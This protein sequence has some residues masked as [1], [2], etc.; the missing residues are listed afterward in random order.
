[1]EAVAH[2]LPVIATS[3]GAIPDSI[4]NGVNG[5]LVEIG[6]TDAIAAG[7]RRYIEEPSLITDHSSRTIE[8]VRLSHDRDVNC[9]RLIKLLD[10]HKYEKNTRTLPQG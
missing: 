5:M 1:L 4:T 2:G 6:D 7:M 8:K 10:I 3:V 9:D